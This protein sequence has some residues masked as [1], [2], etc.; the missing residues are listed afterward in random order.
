MKKI[1]LDEKSENISSKI[2][3]Y[4]A[5][6]LFIGIFVDLIIKGIVVDFEEYNFFGKSANTSYD[7]TAFV[8]TM[9]LVAL[10]MLLIVGAFLTR[11][12]MLA[13]NGIAIWATDCELSRFPIKRYLIVSTIISAI[14]AF[15]FFAMMCIRSFFEAETAIVAILISLVIFAG[16]F[17]LLLLI[18]YIA[19]IV[20]IKNK[21]V[22]DMQEEIV[23]TEN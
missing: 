4:I 16:F 22:E 13:K 18:F 21:K 8:A 11:V 15:T 10:E 7:M 17:A 6:A 1:E 19:Y 23:A 9:T 2:Y 20:V 5:Y 12:F 14:I 3:K